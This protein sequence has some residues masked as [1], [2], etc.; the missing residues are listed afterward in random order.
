MYREF[1]EKYKDDIK[2]CF[3][4][5]KDKD[6]RIKQIPNLLTASRLIAPLF[7][8]PAAFSGNLALAVFFTMLFEATDFVDGYFARKLDAVSEFGKDLDPI[9]DKIFATCLALPLIITNP[10]II[11]NIALEGIIGKINTDSKLKGNIPRTTVLGKIK[12]ASLSLALAC[13]YIFVA[14]G[15]ISSAAVNSILVATFGVQALTAYQYK[16]IDNEKELA[17][18]KENKETEK[19][20]LEVKSNESKMEKVKQIARAN[21]IN[22]LKKLK[23]ILLGINTEEKEKIKEKSL[24]K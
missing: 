1:Y 13:A 24:K 10:L 6:K 2:Q 21:D 5:L 18:T 7:I 19:T 22:E 23:D 17:K 3:S 8:V 14:G 4:D 20:E 16:K 9:V 12:T 15:L 11:G